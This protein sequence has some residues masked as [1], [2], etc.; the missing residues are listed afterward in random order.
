MKIRTDFVTNS[1]SSSFVVELTLQLS[2]GISVAISSHKESGDFD[3]KGCSFVAKEPT[4]QTIASGDCDPVEYCMTEMEFFDPD[5]I[6]YE[7]NEVIDVGATAVNL[8]KISGAKNITTLVAAIT[9]P[10]G[11]DSY[12]TDDDDEEDEDYEEDYEDENAAEIIS[13]LKERFN[14]MVDDCGSVLAE[15][16]AK[17]SDLKS[18][19]VSMEFSGRGEFLADPDEILGHIF[20]WRQKDEIV[21]I[22]SVDD[23]ETLEKLRN[24]KYLKNFSD[25]AL[26]T[27]VDFWNNCDCAPDVCNVTQTL[28][29]DGKIDLAITWE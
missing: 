28:R 5:E 17:A 13:E 26:S 10:F 4:G 27:L 21:D 1:S 15:H 6:P 22:L 23:E 8:I 24:L 19:T 16:L 12:F 20:D 14:T 11:L 9:K 7:V 3:A 2:D 18:A 29:E 25:E